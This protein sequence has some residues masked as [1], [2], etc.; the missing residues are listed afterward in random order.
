MRKRYEES[1]IIDDFGFQTV[2][3]TII[4]IFVFSSIYVYFHITGLNCGTTEIQQEFCCWIILR[5]N[6]FTVYC[7][8]K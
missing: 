4:Y 1:T 5:L 3:V 7:K 6:I 2:I 8:N